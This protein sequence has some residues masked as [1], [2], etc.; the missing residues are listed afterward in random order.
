[1]LASWG[2]GMEGATGTRVSN[3]RAD[4]LEVVTVTGVSPDAT[5]PSLQQQQPRGEE[6]WS[7]NS[8]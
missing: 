5:G 3:C 8:Y 2:L 6:S 1:M 7:R 4:E